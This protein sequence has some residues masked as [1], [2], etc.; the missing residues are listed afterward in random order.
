MSKELSRAGYSKMKTNLERI[1]LM[2][3]LLKNKIKQI[4]NGIRTNDK[5]RMAAKNS[6]LIQ[7]IQEDN[8]F[9]T[10][11]TAQTAI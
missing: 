9:Q 5:E 10:Q 7:L 2:K 11:R 3:I 6:F 8:F 1:T 4:T